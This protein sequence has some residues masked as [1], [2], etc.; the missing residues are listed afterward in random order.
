[1]LEE[2]FWPTLCFCILWRQSNNWLAGAGSRKFHQ[3]SPRRPTCNGYF[4]FISS[5]VLCRCIC[6][7]ECKPHGYTLIKRMF[8]KCNWC[9]A[10]FYYA[11]MEAKKG[12]EMNSEW[13]NIMCLQQTVPALIGIDFLEWCSEDELSICRLSKKEWHDSLVM[14]AERQRGSWD[15][16]ATDCFIPRQRPG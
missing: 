1:M 7:S 9:V 15:T 10:S 5:A 3:G 16:P 11:K 8:E 14:S 2:N 6:L 12:V 4:I 13:V